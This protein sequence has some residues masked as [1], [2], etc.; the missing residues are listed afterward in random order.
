MRNHT[1]DIKST[2]LALMCLMLVSGVE[3]CRNPAQST[4]PP[5]AISEVS[6]PLPPLPKGDVFLD[7][8]VPTADT[9]ID[10]GDTVD[11]VVRRGAGEEKFS[12]VVRESGRASL[13]FVEVQVA[14]LTASQAEVKVQEAF[15]PYMRDPR[16][17]VTLKKKALR[18][19][20]VFVFGDV[21]K[22]GMYPMARNMTVVQA[23]AAAES[24][25]ESALLEEIRVVRGNLQHPEVYTA[26]LSRLYT[27][28][29]WSRNL[30]LEENDIV[31]V[32]RE[33]LGDATEAARK[34]TPVVGAALAPFYPAIIIPTFFP[35]AVIR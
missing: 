25:N 30:A 6:A 29:D 1:G 2:A 5:S 28:G 22:P 13:S 15:T 21:K 9:L 3:G 19:K 7:E 32:P 14:G 20:R 11:V 4:L 34:I 16:A 24:Y 12:S 10:V 26:D 8:T 35:G 31:F 18:V 33:H 27:Y 17:Q 23:V